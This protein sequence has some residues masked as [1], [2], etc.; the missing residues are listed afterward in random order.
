M[1]TLYRCLGLIF[2]GLSLLLLNDYFSYSRK[3]GNTHFY[4]VET[5]TN[6]KTGKP[7]A[8]LYYMTA[9]HSGYYGGN[10][11]GFPKYILWNDKY[12]IS[13]N[14]DGNNSKIVEYIIINL[15]S[16]K[17][18]TGEM[19]DI[20]RFQDKTAYHKYLNQIKLS[21]TEMNHTDNHIAWWEAILT[22][23]H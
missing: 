14:F 23:H 10:T 19:T 4:L 1:R 2:I 11:P 15:D 8:G 16:I 6:S 21:E 13:K 7:L 18:E 12:L 20:H 5:M 3:I 9:N 22:P 17:T